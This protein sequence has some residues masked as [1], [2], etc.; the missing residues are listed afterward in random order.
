[1]DFKLLTL[2]KQLALDIFYFSK[3]FPKNSIILKNKLQETLLN[4]VELLHYYVVNNQHPKIKEKYLKDFIVNLSMIDFYLETSY[5]EKIISFQKYK[6]L[7]SR[8]ITIRKMA[9]GVLKN[10]EVEC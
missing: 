6:E 4:N 1:M 2:S 5:H 9:Y 10:E 3:N 8:V 7:S